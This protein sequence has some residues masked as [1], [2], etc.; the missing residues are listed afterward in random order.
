MWRGIAVP[1][2]QGGAIRVRTSVVVVPHTIAC[3]EQCD[4]R[5]TAL[6]TRIFVVIPEHYNNMMI[7]S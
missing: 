2:P 4:N 6:T 3:A 7:I 5:L 1:V